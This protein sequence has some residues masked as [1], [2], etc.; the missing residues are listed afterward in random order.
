[1]A[2]RKKQPGRTTIRDI[3]AKA[4]V[5]PTTVSRVLSHADYPVTREIRE[6]VQRIAAAMDYVP[7]I[8][9]QMLRGVSS[10]EIGIIVPA[11]D[12]PFYAQLV[13]GAARRCVDKG[14]APLVCSSFERLEL[15]ERQLDILLRQQVA[16]ILLSS[17][18]CDGHIFDK[19]GSPDA[20]PVVMFDQSGENFRGNRILFDFYSGG[21]LAA[22]FLLQ[23]G[24]RRIAFATHPFDRESRRQMFK[25]YKAA[26]EKAGVPFREELLLVCD[27][28]DGDGTLDAN[29]QNGKALAR[30]LFSL[31]S[32]PDAVMAIND[33]TAIGIINA[34]F[35]RGL[36]VPEDISVIGFDDIAIASLIR[37]ALTTVRQSAERTGV[38][39]ADLLFERL[40]GGADLEKTIVVKPELIVRKT[41]IEKQKG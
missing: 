15:E 3:A 28:G 32:L 14:F 39:A 34:L 36:R 33:I 31:P 18:G 35:K 19:L 20:P 40:E 24:H 21:M 4:G 23:N 11:L 5:S 17:L 2:E 8:F 38:L 16:G 25:G 41:V 22:T 9:S 26:L 30:K 29:F 37:P 13:S 1:M 12:N 6:R 27:D 7:N 10:K